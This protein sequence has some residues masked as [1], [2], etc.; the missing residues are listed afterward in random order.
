MKVK[1]PE[2][3]AVMLL[4]ASL[5]ASSALFPARAFADDSAATPAVNPGEI[6]STATGTV[7]VRSWYSAAWHHVETTARDGGWDVYV[8][9]YTYH[10]PYAYTPALLRSYNDYPAGGGIGRGRYNE[11][12]NWEGLVAMEFADSHSKPEYLGAYAWLATWRPFSENSRVGAGL[13]G[14]ITA[15]SDIGHYT[16]IPGVLPVGSIGY[17]F[18]DIQ[19][20]FLP[21][22]KND[23][24]VLFCWAKFSFY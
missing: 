5:F 1:I 20:S 14:F 18:L 2:P 3:A 15:R 13:T 8:P 11:S 21:G 19:A 24:N 12:G 6:P 7:A 10:M 23:G 9:F 16:P 4:L 22:G 17:R